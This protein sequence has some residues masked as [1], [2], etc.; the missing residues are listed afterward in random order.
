MVSVDAKVKALNEVLEILDG[1]VDSQQLAI[2]GAVL[3]LD[4]V[5]FR[6]K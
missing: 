4:T 1:Q 5:T 2:R 3:H 6:E